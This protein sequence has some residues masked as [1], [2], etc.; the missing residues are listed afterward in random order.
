[1]VAANYSPGD[2][3]LSGQLSKDDESQFNPSAE[4]VEQSMS[5]IANRGN[6]ERAII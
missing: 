3:L 4:I 1:M 5:S 6:Q 2:E